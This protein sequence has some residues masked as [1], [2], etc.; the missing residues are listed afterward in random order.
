[1]TGVDRSEFHLHQAG[2]LFL[3]FAHS[4]D[5]DLIRTHIVLT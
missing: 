3:P 5:G 1:M 4:Q 2:L